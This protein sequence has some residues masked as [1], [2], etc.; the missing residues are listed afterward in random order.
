MGGFQTMSTESLVPRADLPLLRGPPGSLAQGL[1]TM[2]AIWRGRP[3]DGLD[4]RALM[5]VFPQL[6]ALLA[7]LCL[8]AAS[9]SLPCSA[10]PRAGGASRRNLAEPQAAVDAFLVSPPVVC[11]SSR[12]G[13]STI[14]WSEDARGL[15]RRKAPPGG[16]GA[17]ARGTFSRSAGD[18]LSSAATND[19]LCHP[20]HS[21]RN[22]SC[23]GGPNA[24]NLQ[25]PL[26]HE[27]TPEAWP[28]EGLVGS[29]RGPLG[30][31]FTQTQ[32]P[33]SP[34]LG[35]PRFS[36]L[37][38][39]WRPRGSADPLRGSH[40]P[41]RPPRP[42]SR[43]PT[44]R[45]T[46]TEDTVLP[47]ARALG[48]Q[49]PISKAFKLKSLSVGGRA[50]SPRGQPFF[51][52]SGRGRS[53]S[54]SPSH[55][56]AW[57]LRVGQHVKA[58][59][60]RIW[61]RYALLRLLPPLPHGMVLDR[62]FQGPTGFLHA[63]GLR[64]GGMPLHP[65]EL[66]KV[67]LAEVLTVGAAFP[68]ELIGPPSA[69][70][71]QKWQ[72]ALHVPPAKG[73]PRVPAGSSCTPFPSGGAAQEHTLESMQEG[74]SLED[75]GSCASSEEVWG[76]DDCNILIEGDEGPLR[77]PLRGLSAGRRRRAPSGGLH[78][79]LQKKRVEELREGGRRVRSMWGG[80]RSGRVRDDDE[81]EGDSFLIPESPEHDLLLESEEAPISA[82]T[83]NL[84][85]EPLPTSPLSMP[86]K[87]AP[88]AGVLAKTSRTS[89]ASRTTAA[90]TRGQSTQPGSAKKRPSC[91][92]RLEPR[93]A[94]VAVLGHVD[95]G[96]TTL[97]KALRRLT[98]ISP[99][100]SRVP[101]SHSRQKEHHEAG[102]IT[103]RI[104]FFERL[105]GRQLSFGS[106]E[107]NYN[108]AAS[109]CLPRC[110]QVQLPAGLA[111]SSPSITFL[112]TPGH[113]AFS[114]MRLRAA[115][116][117]DLAVLVVAANEGVQ[118]ETRRCLQ[119][120]EA[121]KLPSVVALSKT[122][123]VGTARRS[124][125][126]GPLTGAAF[127]QDPEG[128]KILGAL[129]AEGLLTEPLGGP[130]QVTAIDAKG[131]LQEQAKE[132][133]FGG[134]QGDD[135]YGMQ[136]LLECIV[137]QA[138]MLGL[139]AAADGAGKGVVLETHC[140]AARGGSASLLLKEGTVKVGDWVVAGP[141]I[142]RVRRLQF[143][144]YVE[145]RSVVARRGCTAKPRAA[146][147]VEVFGFPTDC[148]P[149]LGEKA[150]VVGSEEEAKKLQAK[151]AEAERS[152]MATAA[153]ELAHRR[154]IERL[155][156]SFT[157]E[158][159]LPVVIKAEAHGPAAAVA[160]ALESLTAQRDSSGVWRLR[161]P[162]DA[163]SGRQEGLS[164]PHL[165]VQ[166]SSTLGDAKVMGDKGGGADSTDDSDSS[167]SS[168][169]SGRKE[170]APATRRVRVLRATAGECSSQDVHACTNEEK[171]GGLLIAFATKVSR[172]AKR[173]AVENH[174]D[175]LQCDAIYDAIKAVEERLLSASLFSVPLPRAASGATSGLPTTQATVK[176]LF[177]LSNGSVVAG[178]D[179]MSG[180]LR[181][182]GVVR[183]VRSGGECVREAARVLSLR[184]GKEA[185]DYVASPAQCG[186]IC[187]GFK[188]WQLGDT[189]FVDEQPAQATSE[190]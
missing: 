49:P 181:R 188:D 96:K 179:V 120:C 112:D 93:A 148:L 104:G 60:I 20:R 11:S 108:L 52:G 180:R 182:G 115:K 126:Q 124:P 8:L 166:Q 55:S 101:S 44:A 33:V 133:P 48:G 129:A 36:Y 47:R 68:V 177:N 88:A 154:G 86:L 95:H 118:E 13:S 189:I 75:A 84:L 116:A 98:L 175:L 64:R 37:R 152:A 155:H 17:H 150:L 26:S 132:K 27:A 107:R 167:N 103:Q 127:L 7:C 144:G 173:Q 24:Y 29:L 28:Q 172:D 43:L 123:L 3:T 40:G 9:L 65:V 58:A 1:L 141:S 178:C 72:L 51:P 153:A 100:H 109:R 91:P 117:A 114:H 135:P 82:R 5:V 90:K 187:G 21:L 168:E 19:R 139:H 157:E 80:R 67:N 134:F 138:E 185:R 73:F 39:P 149:A 171:N 163:S 18:V 106:I 78:E 6:E 81:S 130:V 15:Q 45:A 137:L 151:L 77:K 161:S 105:L 32:S 35:E 169:S 145:S 54:E 53:P 34:F 176:Q 146:G 31:S 71:F 57:D 23:T 2:R 97:L 162:G 30:A 190:R 186:I 76:Q 159:V 160:A 56:E 66:D 83:K 4:L 142:G 119:A 59:C 63:S 14:S 94:V 136:H 50:T 74:P 158:E 110:E 38:S 99:S 79:D 25:E 16:K 62:E 41:I 156:R 111:A 113:A 184:V 102:G 12:K 122:D 164:N 42:R 89:T 140:S 121:L 170:Q 131:F 22:Q 85:A 183:I 92:V 69:A 147:V 143:E 125:S 87:K 46:A 165:Q 128:G 61:A 10:L 174:V 70:N